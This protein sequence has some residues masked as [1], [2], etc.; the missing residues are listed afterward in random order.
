MI[1]MFFW[2]L[3]IAYAL[4]LIYLVLGFIIAFEVSA[5]MS[6]GELAIR[7]LRNHFTYHELYWSVIIFYPMLKLGY[8]LL[9]I[10]PSIFTRGIYCSFDL[11]YLFDELF[12]HQ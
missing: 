4:V 5:A 12:N 1:T 8:F 3:H 6:G 9:E 2:F 10:L 11:D 7:W